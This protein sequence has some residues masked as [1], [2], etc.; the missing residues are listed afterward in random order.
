MGSILASGEPQLPERL[1]VVPQWYACYTRSRAEK[2]VEG[3]LRERGVE[4]YLPTVVR[5]RQWKDR[6]KKVEWPL[7]PGY[8]FGRFTLR[9]VHTVLT[10]PGVSTIVRTNGVPSPVAEEELDN[11]RKLARVVAELGELPPPVRPLLDK[12]EPVV[13]T[14][15]PFKGIFGVVNELRGRHRVLVGLTSIGQGLEIE[16]NEEWVEGLPRD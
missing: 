6:K 15:G 4:S 3:Q 16:V 13:V 11:I 8:V 9:D 1:Y 5:E 10:T 12:G 2:R 7:F 14:A